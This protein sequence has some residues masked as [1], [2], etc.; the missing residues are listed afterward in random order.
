MTANAQ[1]KIIPDPTK[2]VCIVARNEIPPLAIPYGDLRIFNANK[3][4]GDVLPPTS[5][6]S[7]AWAS[8]S[9][10]EKVPPHTH[11]ITTILI[12]FKGSGRLLV[13]DGREF[14]E[15]DCIVIPPYCEAGFVAGP[16]GCHG[17]SIEVGK[18]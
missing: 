9:E 6:F 1:Q 14:S 10:G 3:D 16:D 15:G 11:D 18:R 17:I 12:V 4:L 7:I 2:K 8:L 5:D 13:E